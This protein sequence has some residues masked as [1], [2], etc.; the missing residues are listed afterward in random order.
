MNLILNAQQAI[1]EHEGVIVI[2]AGVEDGRLSLS[3]C[4]DGPGFPQDLL[5]AGIRTFVTH[6]ADGTGLG[7]SMVQRFARA[8]GG[9]VNLYNVEPQGACVTLELPCGGSHV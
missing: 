7:L 5:E 9:N 1:G 3:V 4:D 2:D 8:H 6:R